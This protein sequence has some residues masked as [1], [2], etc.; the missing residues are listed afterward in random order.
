MSFSR[1]FSEASFLAQ[2]S[3]FNN[4]IIIRLN[5]SKRSLFALN[6]YGSS[7][8]ENTKMGT[9]RLT[10]FTPTR[11]NH[12]TTFTKC[13]LIFLRQNAKLYNFLEKLIRK[14][15]QKNF[16]VNNNNKII[17]T[18]YLPSNRPVCR[19]IVNYTNG[20]ASRTKLS[21]LLKTNI[22]KYWVLYCNEVAK[23]YLKFLNKEILPIQIMGK[24][25]FVLFGTFYL[26]TEKQN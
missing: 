9:Y 4:T 20:R 22:Y 1:V 2:N 17:H 25:I 5:A 11:I 26:L 6:K 14:K 7:T 19:S 3:T 15:I 16:I 8:K 23:I 10:V 21:T 24:C 13:L 18:W 12:R